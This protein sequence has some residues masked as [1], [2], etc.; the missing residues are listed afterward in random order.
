MKGSILFI[1][2]TRIGDLIQSAQAV[3]QFKT[4]NPDI[5]CHILVRTKFAKGIE[6]LL[7]SVFDKI[8]YVDTKELLRNG[9]FSNGIE[10]LKEI[11]TEL[12]TNNYDV[13]VNY[14]YNKSSSY[15]H[16]LIESKQKIGLHRNFK[17]E[18]TV[19]DPWSQFVFSNVMRGPNSPFNIVDL[20]RYTLGVKDMHVLQ[21]PQDD[22][23]EETIVLHPFASSKKK[24]WGATRWVELIYKL[25][26]ELPE[27]TFHIVGGPQDTT[28]VGKIINSPALEKVKNQVIS[29]VG[30]ANIADT[31][32]LL[33][34]AKLFIGHDSMVSHLAAETITPS[35]VLSLGTVRPHETTPYS[36]RVINLAP[37]NKCFPCEIKTDC[38]LLPCHTSINHQAVAGIASHVY[39]T[40]STEI[41]SL[42]KE[43]TPF[44]FNQ[45]KVYKSFYTDQGL[46][47]EEQTGDFKAIND[48]FKTYYDIIFQYYL[49]GVD[50]QGELPE[51]T[52]DTASHLYRYLEGTNYLYELF[53]FGIK[54]CN[55]I[56]KKSEEKN[57]NFEAIQK[58]IAKLG[59]IDSL[60]QVT[61]QTYPLL[62]NIVDFFH[63]NKANSPGNNLIEIAKSNLLCY[64]DASNLIAVLS[65]FIKKSAE[66]QIN[67]TESIKE[68]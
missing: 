57:P 29:H 59:E 60:C 63:V 27:T 38:E 24:R 25:T 65:D 4:E 9:S 15:F 34:R 55:Q 61:K 19:T 23:R 49:R 16:S 13:S 20:F 41:K 40:G 3:R 7:E 10:N 18:M 33:Q 11:L 45:L 64:Y 1:Q 26:R 12:N 31:F 42:L 35:I 21:P 47:L 50:I 2:L 6:F 43:M 14:S 5:S 51:I 56:I 8:Y 58:D 22:K 62:A 36:D 28:E 17:T 48:V 30:T 54:Y 52:K 66:Q 67:V 37:K 68:V 46:R 39:K 44:Y 32:R 53:N